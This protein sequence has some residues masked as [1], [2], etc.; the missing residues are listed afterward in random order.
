MRACLKPGVHADRH[1]II[2]P[3]GS[4]PR[5][6]LGEPPLGFEPVPLQIYTEGETLAEESRVNYS[7]LV[8]LEHNYKVFFIG[9]V[10]DEYIPTVMAAVNAC[11]GDS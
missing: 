7:K 2:Y 11:W 9:R 1:G 6:K 4:Q 5:S 3:A 8:T 10:P